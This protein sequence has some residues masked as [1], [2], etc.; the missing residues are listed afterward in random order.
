M[1][2]PELLLWLRLKMR[3][4][5]MPRFRRQHPMGSYVLDFYCPAARLVAEV[6]GWGHNQG[7]QPARDETRDAWLRARGLEVL[8]VSAAEVLADVD[9]TAD[10]LLRLA[11]SRVTPLRHGADAPRHLPRCA[12]EEG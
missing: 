7:D 12:G 10:G 9:A 3:S 4:E 6:D 11:A 8:R 1:T 2:A 5:G